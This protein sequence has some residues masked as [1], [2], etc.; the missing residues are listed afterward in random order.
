MTTKTMNIVRRVSDDRRIR[1]ESTPLPPLSWW[2]NMRADRFNATVAKLLREAVAVVAI[3]EEPTWNAAVAGDAGAAVGLALR[4]N[5]VSSSPA[6]YDLV[7]TAL[8]AC[9]A[10]DDTTACLV[11]AHMLRRRPSSGRAEARI[12]TSWLVRNFTKTTSLEAKAGR[13]T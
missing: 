2:R 7:M 12:A 5:P 3:I 4:L 1:K 9:A 11:M 8:L 10:E 13:S 6:I